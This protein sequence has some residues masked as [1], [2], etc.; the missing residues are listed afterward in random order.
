MISQYTPHA[1]DEA[2]NDLRSRIN[3]TRWPDE[4]N[5]SGWEF[6][7]G[8]TFMKDL[9]DHWKD[10]FN[11]RDTEKLINSFPNYMYEKNDLKIHFLHIKGK[12]KDSIPLI[13]T[14]GWPGSFLEMIKLIPLLTDNNEIVFDLII[15]SIPGFGYSSKVTQPGC[16]LWF[17][18][19]QW[20]ELMEELGYKKYMTQ[21]GD[22]GAGISTA[23]ALKYPENVAGI[24]LN[25]I[26]GSYVPHLPKNKK[27]TKEE[28][29]FRKHVDAWYTKEGSYAHQHRTKPLTL[30]YGLNDSPV[31]LCAWIIEKY[32]SWSDSGV[33]AFN[34]FTK[35]ELLSNVTLYW[36]TETIHSSIR[37]YNENSKAPLVFSANDFVKVPVGIAHFEKEDPFP[38]E[39]YIKRGY[40]IQ[41]WSDFSEGGHFA[42]MEQPETMA[43]DIRAFAKKY[44]TVQTEAVQN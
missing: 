36:L 13:I 24:H 44:S 17:I 12:N 30:A 29:K 38:P 25:Y 31:G 23:L 35:D 33:N 28:T 27:L 21:G 34:I 10:K 42:A 39:A 3:L 7:A 15:P 37:L 32:A 40:N 5:N 20:H 14:H 2:L 19:N 8:L 1:A 41:H 26:P 4:I 11:W 6:G 16:N 9:A 18:A 22:F 43:K